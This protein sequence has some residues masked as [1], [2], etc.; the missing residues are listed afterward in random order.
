MAWRDSRRSRGRLLLFGSALVLGVAALVAIGSLGR[1]LAQTVDTQARMLLGADLVFES[2]RNW[3]EDAERFL[4]TLPTRETAREAVL[5]SMSFFPKAD[6]TRLTQVRAIGGKFPL[7]GALETTPREAAAGFA[8]GKGAVIEEALMLQFELQPGDLIKIGDREIP[9]LGFVRRIPGEAA[10]FSALA[11]RVLIPLAMLDPALQER[12]SLVR[13]KAYLRFDEGVNIPELLTAR[14]KEIDDLKLDATDV[15]RSK[16]QL[17]RAF[18]Q[19]G[20]FLNLV[21]FVSLLLGGI[22]VASG[23]GAYLKGKVRTAALLHCLGATSRQTLAIYLIQALVLGLLGCLVGA[24][25]GVG[26]Q[27]L[28][29]RL[30]GENSALQLAFSLQPAAIFG[31]IGAGLVVC[32]LFAMLPLLPIRLV[33]PLLTLRANAEAPARRDPASWIARGLLAA[34]LVALPWA[35]SGNRALALGFALALGVGILVLGGIA[36]LLTWAARRFTPDALPYAWRQGLANLHRPGNRTVLM[37]GTLGLSTALLLG[38]HLTETL[39]RQQFIRED[40]AGQPNLVFFDIRREQITDA[41]ELL[42]AQGLP[43]LGAVPVVTMRL[44]AVK[45]RKVEDILAD[46][47][48]H[49]PNWVL[50]REY[51]STYRENVTDTE[52]ITAGTLV[53]SVPPNTSPVPIS[54]E[55]EIAKDLGVGLGDILTFDIQGIPMEVKVG[56]LRRVEWRRFSPN[57][58]VVFPLG[59][60]EEAPTFFIAVSRAP[61][62]PTSAR[63]QGAIVRKFPNISAVDLSLVANTV[64]DIISKATSAIRFLS[65][66]TIGTGLIVLISSVLTA[67]FDRIREAVLLRTLGAS[68]QTVFQVLAVEYAAL[69]SLAALTGIVLAAGGAWLLAT[70]VFELSQ[71]ALAAVILPPSLVALAAVM[72]LTLL[73]GLLTSRGVSEHPPLEVLRAEG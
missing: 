73:V 15:V 45:G 59:V 55:A 6:G 60:L 49:T 16:R 57:F 42:R 33:P 30:V 54:L 68:R 21:G 64:R 40:L 29:P 31:G 35:Q 41:R 32:V 17:G 47:T 19:V 25:L 36:K 1:N 9:V 18:D 4:A 11:P 23:I 12:G 10:T 24:I 22:G 52:L 28:A 43:D 63:I 13:H 14:K 70:R 61:D 46:K 38:L 5:A 58:F 67:R 37:L 27:S 2:R 8:A 48:R 39:L 50:S 53:P 56:S 44:S 72:L 71:P 62:G 20:N 65:L 69:G 7:Y 34:G 66:F 3:T 26:L 51:R